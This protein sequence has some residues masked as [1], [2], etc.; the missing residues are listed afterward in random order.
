MQPSC[1]AET[2]RLDGCGVSKL[3]IGK[4]VSA[5]RHTANTTLLA[6]TSHVPRPL[7]AFCQLHYVTIT[8]LFRGFLRD[9]FAST[10]RQG[11]GG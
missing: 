3:Q 6:L 4:N 8:L 1:R 5:V 10:H 7:V 9:E 11:G 2:L